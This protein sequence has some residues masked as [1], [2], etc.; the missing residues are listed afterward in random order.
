MFVCMFGYVE[1]AICCGKMDMCLLQAYKQCGK[2]KM[3][4]SAVSVGFFCIVIFLIEWILGKRNI[5]KLLFVYGV[6]M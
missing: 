5:L 3:S 4:L 1:R 6:Y 2:L